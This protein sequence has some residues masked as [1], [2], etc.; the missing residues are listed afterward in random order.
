MKKSLSKEILEELTS[1]LSSKTLD[2]LLPSLVFV[3]VQSIY[4]LELSLWIALSI[5]FGFFVFRVWQKQT[6]TYALGGLLGVLLASIFSLIANNA[7]NYFLPGII[8]NAFVL[9]IAII[10]LIIDKPLAAYASHLTRGWD[11][12][13][14]WRKDIK[15]AYREV[16]WIWLL[17]FLLRT[18]LQV[19]L[20]LQNNLIQ[21]VWINTLTGLP[22]T[23]IILVLSYIYG[24][25]RLKSLK[26]PG[27]HEFN[28]GLNPPYQG[29]SR[30]F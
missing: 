27:I 26:G 10:S 7:S 18:F 13:W 2:A 20:Y 29:Q 16:T 1:V 24:M 14:F 21:L 4:S 3:I 12:Q 5:S 25:W 28:Q 30:G 19:T 17:F 22:I 23:I 11:I 6:W 8:N 9:L 15:P